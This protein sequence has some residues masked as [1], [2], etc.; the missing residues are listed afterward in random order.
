VRE[1]AALLGIRYRK[2][3]DGGYN[4]APVLTLLDAHGTIVDRIEGIG[5]PQDALLEQAEALLAGR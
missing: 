4:H 2:L 5:A 3:D 1:I